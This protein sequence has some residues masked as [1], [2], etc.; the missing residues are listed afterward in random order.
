M[1]PSHCPNPWYTTITAHEH[2]DTEGTHLVKQLDSVLPLTESKNISIK[3]K[4]I[5][6][7]PG[8]YC[9]VTRDRHELFILY[10]CIAA[11]P[12]AEGAC[13]AKFNANTLERLWTVNLVNT[14]K[15]GEW[16]YPGSIGVHG[17]GFIYVVYGYRLAKIDPQTGAII[18]V[19]RLP[20]AQRPG[21]VAYN[22]FIV[23][24]DGAIVTK[25]VHRKAGCTE[26]GYRAYVKCGA[27]EIPSTLAAINPDTMEIIDDVIT[28]ELMGSRISSGT[29]QQQEYIYMAGIKYL[30]RYIY[31][32]QKL[33]LD[34]SW[35]PVDYLTGVQTN[36][37]APAIFGDYVVLN[38]NGLPTKEPMTMLAISQQ[39]AGIIYRFQPFKEKKYSFNPCKIAVDVANQKLYAVDGLAN[40]LAAV[41]FNPQTGFSLAW[42]VNQS[43][44]SFMNLIGA[45]EQRILV[46]NEIKFTRWFKFFRNLIFPYFKSIIYLFKQEQ[47]VWRDALT[48]K[49]LARSKA[50]ERGGFLMTHGFNNVLYVPTTFANKLYVLT[51]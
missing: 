21:D 19:T 20:T 16:N 4:E 45:P 17:N 29:F 22:G 49:E 30:Y 31:Q 27:S 32:N 50:L 7:L 39:D 12:R 47:V 11:N 40:Q 2:Y 38:T 28:P 13:I 33:Q 51:F 37:S 6:D 24:Q 9:A 15:T 8:A 25:S 42:K 35:S 23:M 44:Y 1:K 10:G 48:G 5:F 3:S 36:G 14:K 26:D 41:N 46:S 34:T 43:S 18:K